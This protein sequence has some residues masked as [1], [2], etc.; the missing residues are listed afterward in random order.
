M[1]DK[2]KEIAVPSGQWIPL[3]CKETLNDCHGAIFSV[4][5]NDAFLYVCPAGEEAPPVSSLGTPMFVGRMYNISTMHSDGKT[6]LISYV[7]SATAS[8]IDIVI[9]PPVV[10]PV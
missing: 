1:L 10:R 8:D 5:G 7:R 4:I 9:S 3:V 6:R 2:T